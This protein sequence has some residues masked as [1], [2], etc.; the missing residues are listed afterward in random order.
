LALVH[1]ISEIRSVD[2]HYLTRQYVSRHEDQAVQ[3]TFSSSSIG[4]EFVALWKEMSE[5]ETL[6]AKIVKDA[7]ILDTNFELVEKMYE[8][9][10]VAEA[11]K[12]ECLAVGEKKLFTDSAK[13]MQIEVWH[14]NPH[15][16]H[17]FSMKNRF[18]G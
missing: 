4:D 17:L 8:G 7:D 6:E 15:A 13:Q 5:K 3:D 1:D 9:H 14:S 16:R 11:W 18:Q 10:K 12:D 2:V